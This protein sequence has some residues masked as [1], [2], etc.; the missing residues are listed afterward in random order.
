MAAQVDERN[1]PAMMRQFLAIKREIP[2]G[3]I[4]MFK[5][6]EFFETFGEDAIATSGIC[7][8]TLTRRSGTPMT[9]FPCDEIDAH[10]ASLVRVGRAVA[11]AEEMEDG[12]RTTR[13]GGICGVIRRE[14]TRLVTPGTYKTEGA[15]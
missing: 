3:V 6:G 1:L 10:L 4:L 9:G 13:Q 8:T 11:L 7:H 5:V 14:V 2:Q 12:G 15:R